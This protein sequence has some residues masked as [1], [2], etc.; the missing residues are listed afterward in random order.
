MHSCQL[1]EDC[2]R[3]LSKSMRE[4]NKSLPSGETLSAAQAELVRETKRSIGAVF[5]QVEL[6]RQLLMKIKEQTESVA[7]S[8]SAYSVYANAAISLATGRVE[9]IKRLESELLV[10]IQLVTA[11]MVKDIW[12]V[13]WRMRSFTIFK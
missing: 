10:R 11:F 6:D 3:T 12:K 1:Y 4:K 8:T 5:S 9:G 2:L 7:K 13:T